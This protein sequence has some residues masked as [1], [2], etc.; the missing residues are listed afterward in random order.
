MT[1]PRHQYTTR[2]S[3]ICVTLVPPGV[4]HP[5][6]GTRVASDVGVGTG[7]GVKVEVS[8]D[9]V[10]V[11]ELAVPG[12]SLVD[13]VDE[14]TKATTTPTAKVTTDVT[15]PAEARRPR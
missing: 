15:M 14:G 4:G 2:S 11:A 10:G 8:A 7:A 12:P 9:A 5:T 13:S 3:T 6:S 1:S